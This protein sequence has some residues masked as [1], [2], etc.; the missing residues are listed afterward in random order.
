[1][2]TSARCFLPSTTSPIAKRRTNVASILYGYPPCAMRVDTLTLNNVCA[3]LLHSHRHTD[4]HMNIWNRWRMCRRSVVSPKWRVWRRCWRARIAPKVEPFVV[5]R[6]RCRLRRRIWML[7][8]LLAAIGDDIFMEN[9]VQMRHTCT[10]TKFHVNFV[11]LPNA[12]GSLC[13]SYSLEITFVWYTDDM[14]EHSHVVRQHQ[15]Y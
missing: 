9:I 14:G 15:T 4:S 1:M 5:C 3:C 7:F 6:C 10:K 11:L 2:R 12:Y 8:H 13:E